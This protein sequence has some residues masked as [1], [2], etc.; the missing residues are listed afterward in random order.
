M[1]IKLGRL[2]ITLSRYKND[3]VRWEFNVTV[4]TKEMSGIKHE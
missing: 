2:W 1:I 3:A 4:Y